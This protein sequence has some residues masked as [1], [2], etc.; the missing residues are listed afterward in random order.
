MGCTWKKEERE[1][2]KNDDFKKTLKIE[3]ERIKN[4]IDQ[5][6]LVKSLKLKQ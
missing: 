6:K 1:N 4:K 2:D 5:D 3:K